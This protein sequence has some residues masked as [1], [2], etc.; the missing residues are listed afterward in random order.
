MQIRSKSFLA[1]VQALFVFGGTGV[2]VLALVLCLFPGVRHKVKLVSLLLSGMDGSLLVRAII[3]GVASLLVLFGV[4][5]L[6]VAALFAAFQW[7]RRK[8]ASR[9]I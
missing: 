7:A 6:V 3:T 2:L 4:P 5:A 1:R 8:L 9:G